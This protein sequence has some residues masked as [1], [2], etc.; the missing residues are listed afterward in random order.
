MSKIVLITGSNS[1][2][3]LATAVLLAEK[4]YKVYATMRNLDKKQNLENKAREKNVN[5]NI[6]QLDVTDDASVKNAVNEVMEKER[7]ID[8]LVNN[9]G[10]GLMGPME[11]ISIDKIKKQFEVN[12]FGLIRITQ[13]VLPQMRKQNSGHI[14]NLSSIAGVRG[15]T[16]ADLYCASKFAVEGLTESMQVSMEGFGIKVSMIEPGPVD[17]GFIAGQDFGDRFTGEN[18]YEDLFAK[19]A[20]NREKRFA[21][22]Q[23]PEEIAQVIL[24]AVTTEKPHLRYPTNDKVKAWT[25]KEKVD[26]YG[27]VYNKEIKEFL[28]L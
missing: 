27:D 26:P 1:G 9:A 25:S 16:A 14:I 15:I 3:G 2:I 23:K 12:F 22:A 7:R 17:T 20:A 5:V 21:A 24:E 6:L 10:Y 13:A 4:G 8:V 11:T 19:I 28:G 18:P